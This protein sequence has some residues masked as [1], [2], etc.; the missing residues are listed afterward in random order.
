MIALLP[1]VS[2]PAI[3]QTN[4]V[5]DGDLGSCLMVSAFGAT[6]ASCI[7]LTITGTETGHLYDVFYADSLVSPVKWKIAEKGVTALGPNLTWT[8]C[9]NP[10][11]FPPS[12]VSSRFYTVGIGDD[13]DGDGLGDAYEVLVLHTDPYQSHTG[14]G[15]LSDGDADLDGDGY[16]N[17]QEYNAGTDPT[18][19]NSFPT[20]VQ[21]FGTFALW[22]HINNGIYFVAGDVFTGH[23]H[24]DDVLYFN[25]A[26]GGP[27]FHGPVTSATNVYSGNISGIEFDQGLTLNSY[28]GSMSDVDFNSA[29]SNSL[30]NIAT[31]Q[32]VMLQGNT[33]ITFNGGTV[34]ITNPTKGWT[35][36]GYVFPASGG[37]IYVAN[38]GTITGPRAGII[39]LEG[40]AIAGRLT[41]VSENDMYVQNNITYTH[42]PLTIPTSTDALGLISQD[43]IWIATSAPNNLTIDAA[44]IATGTSADGNPG[45]FGV[46]NYNTGAL[47]GVLTV[48]GG[49]VQE[50]RG[51]VGTSNP[52]GQPLSGYMKNYIYDP[53]FLNNPPPYYPVILAPH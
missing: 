37:I 20:S 34:S 4:D 9:G 12:V 25:N 38:N 46:I 50:K 2:P 53:R 42:N 3:A 47:R 35:N 39:Y 1:F 43:D 14:N 52:Y 19:P 28:Q 48:L 49:I 16:S 31:N 21:T 27:V 33:T 8:D 5:G 13:T 10:N 36:H 29:S 7:T 6:S 41:V 23:V 17:L 11:R 51:A 32:G 26:G 45:S 15:P 18:D 44:M 30:K 40:G 22:S 24:A